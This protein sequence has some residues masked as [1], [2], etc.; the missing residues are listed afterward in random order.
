MK[1]VKSCG[2]FEEF[3]FLNIMQ[4]GSS[5]V[6]CWRVLIVFGFLFF[7]VKFHYHWCRIL[8]YI[9]LEVLVFSYES[10]DSSFCLQVVGFY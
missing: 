6:L 1:G 10:Y 4:V 5:Y 3:F 8:L 2:S 7:E 9:L